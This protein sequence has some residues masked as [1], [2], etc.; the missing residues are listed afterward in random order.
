[1]ARNLDNCFLEST[2]KWQDVLAEEDLT[3]RAQLLSCV[4]MKFQMRVI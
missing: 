2:L 3:K 1:M 4:A